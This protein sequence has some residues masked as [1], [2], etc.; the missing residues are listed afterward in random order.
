MAPPPIQL[1]EPAEDPMRLEAELACG[2]VFLDKFSQDKVVLEDFSSFDVMVAKRHNALV[3]SP[4]ESL[5][6]GDG[7]IQLFQGA[8]ETPEDGQTPLVI[9]SEAEQSIGHQ[10]LKT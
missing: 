2:H 7:D 9:R 6:L 1:P 5:K 4:I 3:P 10:L 8:Q